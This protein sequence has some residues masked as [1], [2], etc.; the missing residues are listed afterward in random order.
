MTYSL[1]M[2]SPE[3]NALFWGGASGLTVSPKELHLVQNFAHQCPILMFKAKPWLGNHVLPEMHIFKGIAVLFNGKKVGIF[4]TWWW[5]ADAKYWQPQM[6]KKNFTHLGWVNWNIFWQKF[7][8]VWLEPVAVDPLLV[9][10]NGIFCL[11]LANWLN[12]FS[13]WVW[14]TGPGGP[15]KIPAESFF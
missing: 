7:F 2:W 6:S 14:Q 8:L 4:K 5:L 15:L 12:E 1:L 9:D 11:I 13:F 10:K 3:E